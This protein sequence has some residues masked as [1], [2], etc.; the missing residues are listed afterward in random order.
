[1]IKIAFISIYDSSDVNSWSGTPYYIS[2]TIKKYIGEIEFI[3]HLDNKNF[4][5]NNFKKIYFKKIN[6]KLFLPERTKKSGKYLANQVKEKLSSNYYDFIISMGVIPI[7]FLETNIPIITI[8]DANFYS[9][10]DYY[11]KNL[12][13]LSIKDGHRMEYLGL[14][15]SKLIVFSSGWAAQSAIEYY[16]QDKNKVVVIPFG[17][18]LNFIPPKDSLKRSISKPL[19]LL[20]IGKEWE[21]KGGDIVFE[22]FAL[23]NKMGIDTNLTI[24]GTTPPLTQLNPKLK[25]FPFLNKKNENDRNIINSVMLNTDIF[26]MPSRE[27]CYGI[28]FCESNAYGIPC[29]AANTG[30]ISTIIENGINGY[31]LPIS[32]KAIDY[33]EKINSIINDDKSFLRLRECSRKKFEEL[34]NWDSFGKELK[35]KMELF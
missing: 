26:F 24:I 8:A 14:S 19:E 22:T 21:R 16:K 1:M 12:C 25:I 17:A 28:V 35:N 32:S 7:A 3:G 29:L 20:F 18:N 31:L 23:L 33:L 10:K 2:K 34:L 9:M 6:R 15:K 5:I 27:E 4:L 11:F 13:N 30:G